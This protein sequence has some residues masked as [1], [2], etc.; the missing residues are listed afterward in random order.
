[1]F[2]IILSI[3]SS[4]SNDDLKSVSHNASSKSGCIPLKKENLAGGFDLLGDI[5]EVMKAML[6]GCEKVDV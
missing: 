1:M 2:L 5:A 4:D 3:S 6:L